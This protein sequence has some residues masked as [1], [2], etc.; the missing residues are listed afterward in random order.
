MRYNSYQRGINIPIDFI[1]VPSDGNG[2]PNA[3]HTC[4]D[5]SRGLLVRVAGVLNVTMEGG[6]RTALPFIAGIN[7]GMFVTVTDSTAH[8]DPAAA[9]GVWEIV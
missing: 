3:T 8:T 7:P 1:P 9:Q 6:T 2:V 5:N 4:G